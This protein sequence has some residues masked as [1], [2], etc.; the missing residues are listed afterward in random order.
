MA[1][2]GHSSTQAPHSVHISGSTFALSS[3][4]IASTGHASTQAPQPMQVSSSTFAGMIASNG[5]D[6]L[7]FSS[8]RAPEKS[9]AFRN[10]LF[11]NNKHMRFTKNYF[12]VL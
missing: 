4:V 1:S 6:F 12:E 2:D 8:T 5:R 11:I 9:V 3:I 10:K 7:N